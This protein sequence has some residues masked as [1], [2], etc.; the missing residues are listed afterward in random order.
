[1][2]YGNAGVEQQIPFSDDLDFVD[3][4]TVAAGEAP[5]KDNYAYRV[6][7][8]EGYV[9]FIQAGTEIAPE[10]RD[11]AGNKLD[12]STRVLFQKCT[13]QGNPIDEFVLNQSLDAFDYEKMRVDPDF[14]N[15]TSKDLM[16]DEREIVKIFLEIPS[17]AN[18]FD[19]AKSRLTIG[20]TTSDYGTPVEIIDHDDL[21]DQESQ[22]VKAASQRSNGG[23]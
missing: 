11:S 15:Y 13:K 16:L 6:K 18:D 23:R 1:M 8:P 3:A 2:E 21:S 19:P 22:A 12:G 10:L 7:G 14:F 4:Q 5:A 17:G 20:N 9:V